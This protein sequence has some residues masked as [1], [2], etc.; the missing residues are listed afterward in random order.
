M[1]RP[2]KAVR[3]FVTANRNELVTK[4]TGFF[5]V[6]GA[7]G[8]GTATGDAEALGYLDEII[9]TTNWRLDRIGLFGGAFRLRSLGF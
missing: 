7:S 6:S 5:Q 4:P 1:G 8:E 3:T 2:Q 9:E